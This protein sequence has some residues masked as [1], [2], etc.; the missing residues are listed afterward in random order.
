MD[1]GVCHSR[2]SLLNGGLY[3]RAKEGRPLSQE[4]RCAT[5]GEYTAQ[6]VNAPIADKQFIL[7]HL[8]DD[9][10]LVLDARSPKE[11][12]GVKLLAQKGGHIPG[13]VNLEWTEVLDQESHMRLISTEQISALLDAR[14][15][16]PE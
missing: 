10:A 16:S 9:S 1:L 6:F 2:F 7:E 8:H 13:A 4:I 3:A 12:S 11:F 15:V 14:G 5:L